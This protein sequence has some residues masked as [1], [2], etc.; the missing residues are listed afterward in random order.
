MSLRGG[1]GS[2]GRTIAYRRRRR[3]RARA[4]P[5]A[6]GARGGKTV[7]ATLPLCDRPSGSGSPRTPTARQRGGRFVSR[8]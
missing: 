8:S 5:T 7:I 3:R 4:R 6:D 2:G 1:D